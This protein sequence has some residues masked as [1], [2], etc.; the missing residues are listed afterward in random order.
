MR[1]GD[2]GTNWASILDFNY[3][4]GF[5]TSAF[6]ALAFDS[7]QNL[8]A[9][10]VAE[11]GSG[12]NNSHWLVLKSPDYGTTWVAAMDVNFPSLADPQPIITPVIEIGRASCRERSVD[13]GGRR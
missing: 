2:Q 8:Y 13:L 9:A 7:A 5:D 6:T 3:L 12:T 4:P 11:D 1:S 10:G